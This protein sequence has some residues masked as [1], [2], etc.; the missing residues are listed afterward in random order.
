MLDSRLRLIVVCGVLGVALAGCGRKQQPESTGSPAPDSLIRLPASATRTGEVRIVSAAATPLADTLVLSGE[1]QPNPLRV[2]HVSSRVTGTVQRVAA[3]VGDRVRRGQT[4]ALLYSPEFLAAQS[5]YLLAA[6]RAERSKGTGSSDEPA[7]E[8][9]AHSAGQR[10]EVL[11]ASG[12]DLAEARRRGRSLEVLPLRAPIGGVVTQVQATT[13]KQ[14]EAG[15]DLFGVA[16]LSEV[17]AVVEVYE[18]DVGRIRPGKL[19]QITTT[20]YPGLTLV[21]RVTNLENA[22]KEDTRTL[23]V[24]IR[25]PNPGLALKPGMFV[26]ARLATGATRQAIVLS[27]AAVQE[28]GGRKVVFVAVTDSQFIARPVQVRSLGG[29]RVEIVSGLVP[30]SRVASEGAF[31]IKSQAFKGELGDKD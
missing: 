14:V 16:D 29:D 12:T 25:V 26:M 11:G 2:A 27:E 28:V 18:A 9:I 1:V 24:R 31:L 5:D 30:G 17:Q 23:G 4:L 3:V 22:L 19:A 10:L 15:A 6:E 13:G 8:S 21:G 20:A 7:L